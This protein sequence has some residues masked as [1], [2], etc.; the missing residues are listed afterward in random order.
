MAT[1][2]RE[3]LQIA[4]GV[5]PA[6]GGEDQY[7]KATIQN[8]LQDTSPAMISDVGFAYMH[9]ANAIKDACAALK[10]QAQA[11]AG[12]WKGPDAAQVQEALRM[13]YSTGMEI[14]T[15]MDRMST[16]VRTYAQTHLPQAISKVNA[17]N[18]G[19]TAQ[20]GSAGGASGYSTSQ[21]AE[22]A[23]DQQAANAAAEEENRQ[24][25]EALRT[26]NGELN[27][28]WAAHVPV[29]IEVDLPT[30]N[31]G[32]GD[33]HDPADPYGGR[34]PGD[35]VVSG[36]SGGSSG[37]NG[38]GSGGGSGGGN[39]GSAGG[40]Y[41]G[42]NTGP[43]DGTTGGDQRG[44]RPGGQDERGEDDR[45]GGNG[46]DRP[47]EGDQTNQPGDQ[48][49]QP[50]DQNAG[51]QD[52]RG[53]GGPDSSRQ[54]DTVPPVIGQDEQQHTRLGDTDSQI[55]PKRTENVSYDPTIS[56][57]TSTPHQNTITT[58]PTTPAIT[59]TTQG[60][61]TVIGEPMSG[62]PASIP[63]A[64]VRGS[65]ATPFLGMP[66]APLG[67]AGMIGDQ[68]GE[69]VRNVNLPV[70]RSQWDPQLDEHTPVSDTIR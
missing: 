22:Q 68:G 15:K 39:S 42:G 65:G 18:P 33:G 21:Q 2:K 27:S 56:Q 32:A 58:R 12:V 13:L 63:S 53:N 14:S 23:A 50:G 54:G 29:D 45:G 66:Y 34:N 57:P 26:L 20:E 69:A 70:D 30:I 9:A 36:N 8:L 44:D 31:L 3:R 51:D 35:I 38:D 24:A 5:V 48:S 55:D 41:R 4:P 10:T 40:G 25:R 67:H 47:G 7:N 28:I 19:D 64:A 11:L 46:T 43:H 37:G 60:P 59:P 16:G 1:G 6:P 62:R 61:V 49:N 52:G 17:I